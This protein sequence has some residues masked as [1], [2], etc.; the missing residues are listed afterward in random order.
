MLPTH[1]FLLMCQ[2]ISLKIPSGRTAEVKNN[3]YLAGNLV[4][5]CHLLMSLAKDRKVLD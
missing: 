1:T 5:V 3:C 2:R 4:N